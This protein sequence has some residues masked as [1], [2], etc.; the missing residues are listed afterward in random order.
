[1]ALKVYNT[2]TRKKEL[3][4]P[5]EKNKVR[6]YVCGP[7]VYNYIHIGNARPAVVFDT[8]RRYFEYRGYIVRYV[9]NFTDVDDRLINASKE[10]HQSVPEIAEQFIKAY[11]EDTGA[12]NVKTATVHPRATETMPEIIAFISKLVDAGYAYESEGDVYFRTRKFK[13]YGK[14]SH[15]S[16]DDLKSGARIEIG[17]NKEDPLDFALWKAAKPGEIKW[18][19]P[20]GEGRPGWHIECSAMVEKYLGDTIDIHA[21][22]TDLAF[23]H[24]EN[25]IAQSESLHHET[26][27][28]YWLHNGHIQINHEKMS[29]SIGNVIL[30]HDLIKK[31]DPQVI[32]FF[33]LSVQYRHP[34][35]F[36]DALLNDA[37]QAFGRLKTTHYNLNHRLGGTGHSEKINEVLVEN[38]RKPFIEAMDDD[39]N[40]ANAIAVLFDIARDANIALQN[41]S[42]SKNDLGAYLQALTELSAVLGLKLEDESGS[43]LDNEVEALIQKRED[44]RKQRDFAV[45]DSIR[46][47][48]KEAGIILEDTPQ[49][50]RWK[51]GLE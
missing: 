38:Y 48:L 34:I 10:R 29:K 36:S 13:D 33:I 46:D 2:L 41:E 44:A 3:F 9:S 51:R 31:F 1:M 22:G 35:N 25:E 39:F 8:V 26:M 23:P 12:L 32:R 4:H 14:L 16:I 5:I 19:S 40:T 6:M 28:H 24:H 15:Q 43:I 21:G 47:Q 50:V 11:K 30:V 37:V 20:W 18:A 45:A 17:E 49:G 27:A 42:A 7:T